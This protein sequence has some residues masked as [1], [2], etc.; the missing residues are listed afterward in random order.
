MRK[1]FS[2]VIAL[3]LS[4]AACLAQV[5]ADRSEL[6]SGNRDFRKEQ[7]KDADID[8][9]RALVKD[10]LS[11]AANYNLANTLYRMENSQEAAKYAEAAAAAVTEM[12][13]AGLSYVPGSKRE[14]SAVAADAYY[15]K[16]N[17]ALQNKD[18]SGAFETFKQSLLRNP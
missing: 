3:T 7:W 16:G 15:N 4:C 11:V 8:Y 13:Q 5:P 2:Y 1:F 9:R 10:S 17:I 6:R 12:E 18:Y 14:P